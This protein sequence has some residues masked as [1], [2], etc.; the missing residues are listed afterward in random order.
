MLPQ[1][2]PVKNVNTDTPSVLQADSLP[3]KHAG[4]YVAEGFE[5]LLGSK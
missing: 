5:V 3:V 1:R 4:H 2:L